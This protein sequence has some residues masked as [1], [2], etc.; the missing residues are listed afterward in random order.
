MQIDVLCFGVGFVRITDT[1]VRHI[2][3]AAVRALFR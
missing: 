3:A 1:D 2:P